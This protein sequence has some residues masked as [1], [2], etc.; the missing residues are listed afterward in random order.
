MFYENTGSAQSANHVL[1]SKDFLKTLDVGNNSAP[2]FIDIDDDGDLDLFI[3][4]LNNPTGSIHFLEN[5]GTTSNPSF[6]YSDSSYFNILS[7]LVVSPAFGDLDNDGDFD[8]LI[9]KLNGMVEVYLNTGT[10]TAPFFSNGTILLNNLGEVIDVG[11]SSTPFFIDSDDDSDLDLVIGGFNGRLSL[12]ENTGSAA[13][14]QFTLNSS[15]FGTLDVGDNCTPF[16]IDYNKDGAYDLFSG[17][18]NGEFF[19][20]RNDGSNTEPVWTEV[21]NQFLP[22]AFGGNTF[23]C[24]VDIDNDTDSD[25]FLGNVKGGLYLYINSEITNI[26]EWGLE[27]VS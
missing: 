27:P 15:Y 20:F 8:L 1:Q 11:S 6:T 24:F 18:R 25:L 16:M 26:A 7:D 9:G 4:S 13:S 22:D 23:P 21:T 14:Y 3:G 2:V 17:N 5:I 12:Y 19:Y 10:S